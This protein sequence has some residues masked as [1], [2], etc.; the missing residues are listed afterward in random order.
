MDN[1]AINFFDN[2]SSSVMRKIFSD[3]YCDDGNND[4]KVYKTEM[5]SRSEISGQVLMESDPP[6]AVSMLSAMW[7]SESKRGLAVDSPMTLIEHYGWGT[8]T[9]ANW[10]KFT[11]PGLNSVGLSLRPSDGQP[12]I[13]DQLIASVIDRES[14]LIT[15]IDHTRPIPAKTVIPSFTLKIWQ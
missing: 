1:N 9:D 13:G 5:V 10:I 6:D 11:F 2:L 8:R 4:N 12:L 7:H 15:N 3:G 14:I